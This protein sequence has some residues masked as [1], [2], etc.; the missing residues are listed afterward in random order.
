MQCFAKVGAVFS[1]REYGG[2]NR[3]GLH[4]AIQNYVTIHD[5]RWRLRSNE[6]PLPEILITKGN[7]TRNRQIR[8]ICVTC[9]K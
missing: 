2:E 4:R 7:T 8:R 9:I 5:M 6:R 1:G 3:S